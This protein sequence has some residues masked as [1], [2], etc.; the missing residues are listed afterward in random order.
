[1]AATVIPLESLLSA[2]TVWS[3]GRHVAP[4]PLGESTGFAALDALLPHG[5]WPQGAL[6]ELLIPA[7]GV[8]ELALMMPTLSRMTQAG[9]LVALIAP[10]FC[11]YAPAWQRAG[12]D[13]RYLE[14]VQASWSAGGRGALWAFEQCLRSAAFSAVL[15]WPSHADGPSLRRLQVAADTGQCLGFAVRDSRH[16]DNPSPAALRIE[17]VED[18]W[19]VRKC[20]GGH[21]PSQGFAPPSHAGSQG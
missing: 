16:A 19:R 13:L 15:G 6:T 14:I 18:H 20:R 17:R 1:M 21:V 4:A 5:G 10:P 8:G 7:D 3:A 11:P 9:R 2:R 12:V